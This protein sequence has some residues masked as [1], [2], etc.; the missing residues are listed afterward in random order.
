MFTKFC[1]KNMY[2]KEALIANPHK[3]SEDTQNELRLHVLEC[4]VCQASMQEAEDFAR[5]M[6]D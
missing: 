5:M 1:E 6:E 4:E 3:Y 2:V